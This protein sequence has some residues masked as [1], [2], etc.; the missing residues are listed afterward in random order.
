M[1]KFETAVTKWLPFGKGGIKWRLESSSKISEN[2][3]KL[4]QDGGQFEIDVTRWQKFLNNRYKI[5]TK[6]EK[7]VTK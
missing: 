1:A 2:L 4:E 6:F 5:S 3:K 7:A